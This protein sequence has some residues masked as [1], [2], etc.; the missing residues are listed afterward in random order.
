MRV[1]RWVV[2]AG[3]VALAPVAASAQSDDR[4]FLEGLLEDNLSGAGR[5]V[6]VRGFSGA[7]S[8]VA[9]I[10]ELTVADDQGV[11]LTLRD[12]ELDWSRAALFAGRLSVNRLTAAEIVVARAPVSEGSDL[13]EA[14]AQ[15]FSLPEL[16]V[17]VE[18]GRLATDRL[19]LGASL[20]GEPVTATIEGS[21]SLAG[22]EGRGSLK[23]IRTDEGPVTKLDASASFANSS[24]RLVVDLTASEEANGLVGG[25]INLPGRPDFELTVKGDGIVDAM[26]V[27]LQ[28][29]TSG[30]ERLAGRLIVQR[31]AAQVLNFDVD[32]GGNVAPMF[33][34]DYAEFFG[35]DIRLQALAAAQPDGRIE[36]SRLNL[37]AQALSLAGTMALAADGLPE[38][39]ALEGRVALPSGAPVLLPIPGSARTMVQEADVKLGFDAARGPDWTGTAVVRGL[40]RPDFGASEMRVDA[41]GRI[42]REEGGAGNRIDG[43]VSFAG[44]GLRAADEALAEALGPQISGAVQAVWTEAAGH[45]EI[46]ALTA[47]GNHYSIAG[48]GTVDDLDTGFRLAGD[49]QAQV[50]DASRFSGLAGR[51]LAGALQVTAKG[52]GSVLDGSFD[53]EADVQGTNLRL[54]QSQADALLKGSSILVVSARRDATGLLLREFRAETPGITASAQGRLATAGSDLTAEVA[55]PDMSVLGAAAR[56]GVSG[57][58]HV[59]GTTDAGTAVINLTGNDMAIGQAQVDGLLRGASRVDLDLALADGKVR[60]RAAR[61]D[62]PQVQASASGSVAVDGTAADLDATLALRD[63]GVMGRGF[64]GSVD[65]RAQVSGN[66][67]AGTLVLSASTRN[68]S[69]GQAQADALLRGNGTMRLNLAMRDGRIKVQEAVLNNPQLQVSANGALSGDTQN[70]NVD[71]RLSNLGLVVPEFPGPVSVTGSVAQSA[72]GT[73][74]DLAARGPGGIDGTVSGRISPRYD[75]ADLAVRGSAQAALANAFLDPRAVSGLTRFDLR[76]NGP[77]A[78]RSLSGTV[79]LTGGRYSDPSLGLAIEQ[80]EAD[81]RL[82]SGRA[83]VTVGGR[84]TEGGRLRANGTIGLEAPYPGDLSVGLERVVLVDPNL[85]RTRANGEIAVKGPLAGGATISGRIALIET[86]VRIP[87]TLG[88]TDIPEG[89]RHVDLTPPIAATLERAGLLG[90]PE[91]ATAASRRRPFALQLAI[92]APNQVFIRGRG[93][94]AELGGELRLG[95]TS[96]AIVPSGGFDLIRGRL[97]ILGKRLVL[98]RASLRLEGDFDPYLD[99]IAS[100]QGSSVTTFVGIEGPASDPKVSFW[101]SPELPEEEVLSQLLFD[102]DLNSLSPLQ[103]A[104]LAGAVA[105]L[106]GKGGVGLIG[107]LRGGLGLDDFDVNTNARGGTQVTAGKYLNDRTYTEV[108]MDDTGNS[109]IHLNFDLTDTITLRASSTSDGDSGVGVYLEKDY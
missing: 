10:Q 86:E 39:F 98:T 83:T 71:A 105:T 94:D 18:I 91:D 89:L 87:D 35:P 26:A 96:A 63:L 52:S 34:P 21:L 64:G 15:P 4:S 31:D 17:S 82:A 93:L 16:P 27:R 6:T 30:E 69:V 88:A 107:K 77:I 70:L 5:Q 47:G 61:I 76:L 22:G 109:E 45:L 55:V 58:V 101:S 36:V 108:Q 102:R 51:P 75:S 2:L 90:G 7:L 53:V 78:L 50:S 41:R 73:T 3:L 32:L 74:L 48:T 25:M 43:L 1:L 103:A 72:S 8:S 84:V 37:T 100:N 85:Y 40:L 13:P 14:E 68:L 97:D 28:L 65:A 57:K 56:G 106:A 60:V 95:G 11:W 81:A 67:Q 42:E 49:I 33:V 19:E 80:L 104:R 44:R 79:T 54:G 20:V 59:A 62:N 66:T 12:I 99:V 23:A 92:S 29:S 38:R 46:K 9:R 24:R